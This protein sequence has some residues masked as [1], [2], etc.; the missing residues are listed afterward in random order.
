MIL[1]SLLSADI[2]N[3]L[4]KAADFEVKAHLLYQHIANQMQRIGLFGAQEYFLHES[5]DEM[6][7]Y[8]RLAD[9]ANDMGSVLSNTFSV[10]IDNKI[11]DLMDALNVSYATEKSLMEFYQSFYEDAEEAGDCITSTFLIDF[12]QIQRKS[13]GEYGDLISRLSQN[14]ENIFVFDSYM[15]SLV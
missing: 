12:M 2:Q 13:V 6:T 14:E 8:Q 7:H 15:K 5:K 4:N 1:K 10:K 11:S 9:Y 3:K